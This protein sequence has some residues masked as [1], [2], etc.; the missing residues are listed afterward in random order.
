MNNSQPNPIDTQSTLVKLNN[1]YKAYE[2]GLI[3]ALN[4]VSLT[5]NKGEIYA[6]TGPSGCGKSTL[7]NIIGTIDF[8]TSG[9][10]NYVDKGVAHQEPIHKFRNKIIGFIFQFHHL[11]P[12]L[13]L[14]ENVEASLMANKNITDTARQ[15]KAAGLLDELGLKN[16]KGA[17]ANRVS[18]GERQRA[19]I[20]RAMANDPLLILADE[21][22]GSVDSKTADII[23]KKLISYT[24]NVNGTLLIATHD[25]NIANLAD[26][27]IR[28]KD[29]KITGIENIK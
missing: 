10:V 5:L 8:P 22:T 21:P 4:D 23:L 13:T 27:I 28:M 26:T 25:E 29:G 1:V 17:Y 19:A 18:G 24:K 14:Q 3:P 7:L 16:K 6:L 9:S 20:A 2:G 12:L 15:G 11:L